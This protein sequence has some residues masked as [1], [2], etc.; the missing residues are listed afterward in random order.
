MMDK[1]G[2]NSDAVTEIKCDHPVL[3]ALNAPLL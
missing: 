3:Q 1:V 2:H